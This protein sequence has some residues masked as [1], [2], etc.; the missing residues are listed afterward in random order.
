ML[1]AAGTA[2]E[3]CHACFSGKYPTS[4]PDDYVKLRHATPILA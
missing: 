3:W 2:N 4:I 1:K